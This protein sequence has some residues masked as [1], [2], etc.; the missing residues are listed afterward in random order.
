M[1]NN[2]RKSIERIVGMPI[3]KIRIMTQDEERAQVR[4]ISSKDLHFSKRSRKSVYG[5]GNPLLA[6][7]KYR[8]IDYIDGKINDM[9]KGKF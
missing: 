5:R 8:T 3:D 7:K 9:V 6:R 2:I 4:K 1:S